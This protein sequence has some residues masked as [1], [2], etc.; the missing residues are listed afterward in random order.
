MNGSEVVLQALVEQGVEVVFGYPGGA[1]LPIY[2]AIFKQDK[3][4]HILVRHEQGAVHAAEGYARSTGKVGVVLVTSGPGRDQ[5]RD[6]P[7]RR[8]DGQ[9]A[10]GLPDRPGADPHDRQ[11]RLPGG[12]H[13]R[14]HAALHQ[15]QLPREVGRRA[16][17]RGPRGLPRRA[18]RPAGPGRGRPAQGHP[19]GAGALRA[20]RSGAPSHLQP[21]GRARGRA[22]RAGGRADGQ[23]RAP[24]VLRRRRRGQLGRRGRGAGHRAGARDRLPDH[25]DA[26]G[27]R[28]LSGLRPAV[29]RHARHARH[30]RGQPRDARLRRDDRDR[31]ALRRPGHRPP[32][33]V[34][35]RLEEDPRR[36]RPVV[37]QQ[38]RAGRR[39]GGGRCRLRAAGTARGVARQ[40]QPGRSRAAR[41]LVAADQGLAGRST[42]CATAR[43]A[44]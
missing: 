10:G 32:R 33:Q 34:L 17:P 29:H 6:R 2:D 43:T 22:D 35:A 8:A 41:A 30:L 1:V 39:R 25:A 4:R 3:V 5:H 19:D 13:R 18:Q 44:R 40:G 23:G 9:R 21:A 36:H 14:H 38:E 42:A 31:R 28:R 7:D 24:G 26:D 27:A 16:G 15:A 12:R 11:R 20:A 37:D